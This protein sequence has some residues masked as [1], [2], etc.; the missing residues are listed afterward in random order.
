M[1]TAG[2]FYP[3]VDWSP[4]GKYIIGVRADMIGSELRVI[5]VDNGAQLPIVVNGDWFGP[6]WRR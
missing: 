1:L 2:P 5:D 4:D 6:S 3:G